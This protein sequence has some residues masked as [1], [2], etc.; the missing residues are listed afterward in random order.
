MGIGVETRADGL[1]I[2]GG[3]P[4]AGLFKSHGD[5]RIAMAAAIAGLIS[6]EKVTVSGWSCVETSFPGFLDTLGGVLDGK[7]A[8]RPNKARR[9]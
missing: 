2:R 3:A 8:G 6:E 7:P 5:H 9:E 1:T 4:R